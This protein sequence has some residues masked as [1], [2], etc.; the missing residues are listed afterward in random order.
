MTGIWRKRAAAGFHAA[1]LVK[2]IF[3][4]IVLPTAVL[5]VVQKEIFP[6]KLLYR[7]VPDVVI[8]AVIA[9]ALLYIGGL[10][11]LLRSVAMVVR[12]KLDPEGFHASLTVQD[13]EEVQAGELME[14]V[15]D[16]SDKSEETEAEVEAAVAQTQQEAA[17]QTSEATETPEATETSDVSQTSESEQK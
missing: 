3:I 6:W 5:V 11:K 4:Q 1:R 2:D 16:T 14:L 13:G 17:S 10:L 8:V 12:Y 15:L 7:I 9:I